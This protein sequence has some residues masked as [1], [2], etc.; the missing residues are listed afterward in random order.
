MLIF[1][2]FEFSDWFIS[3]KKLGH[4]LHFKTAFSIFSPNK[5]Y[6][7]FHRR[8]DF[9]SFGGGEGMVGYFNIPFYK[10]TWSAPPYTYEIVRVQ[11]MYYIYAA[12][13]S[14]I[15]WKFNSLRITKRYGFPVHVPKSC[16]CMKKGTIRKSK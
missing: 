10:V 1:R 9:P 2:Y 12:S 5:I 3:W 8:E 14:D 15:I 13:S 4:N 11:N 16:L 7:N 6:K